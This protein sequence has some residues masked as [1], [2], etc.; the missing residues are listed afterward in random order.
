MK[1]IRNYPTYIIAI[2]FCPMIASIAIFCMMISE[3]YSSVLFTIGWAG[4][5]FSVLLLLPVGTLCLALSWRLSK[6]KDQAPRDD[7]D[8]IEFLLGSSGIMMISLGAILLRFGYYGV[9][10][11]I[12]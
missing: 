8:L 3:S 2:G 12:R 10:N 6:D 4:F 7:H 1:F 9:I 5:L 11:F